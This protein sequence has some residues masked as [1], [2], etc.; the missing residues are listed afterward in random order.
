[1]PREQGAVPD[2]VGLTEAEAVRAV[3][4]VELVA[5]IRY[6]VDAPRT[7]RVLRSSPA[8]GAAAPANAV[9]VLTTAPQPRLPPPSADEEQELHAL[10]T[11]VEAN[12]AAFV[13][14]YVGAGGTPHVVFGRGA[15]PAQWKR[16][17]DAAAGSRRYVTETCARDR[18][19]LR[20]LQDELRER[21]WT[22]EESLAF[23]VYVHPAT[24]TVRV[25]SDL[26]TPAEIDALAARFGTAISIDTTPGSHPVPLEGRG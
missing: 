4:S 6:D 18:A 8:A 23:G 20:A 5:N 14:L 21:T 15:E 10:G 9:V 3:G 26:L 24:C 1:V 13:G 11:L 2:V 25:E 16:R 12:A 22:A 17:L 7:G 19:T